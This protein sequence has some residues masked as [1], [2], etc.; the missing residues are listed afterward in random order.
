MSGTCAIS[1][2]SRRELS[3]SFF[4]PARQGKAPKEIW[5]ILTETL[6]CFLPGRAKDLS[7]PLYNLICQYYARVAH[8]SKIDCLEDKL[9]FFTRQE[10]SFWPR[11]LGKVGPGPTSLS[12]VSAQTNRMASTLI[13]YRQNGEDAS[14]RSVCEFI[15]ESDTKLPFK[16]F[17]ISPIYNGHT[18]CITEQ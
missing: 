17:W 10:K 9:K 3:S 12:I 13:C 7:A 18:R 8:C 11:R 14:S 4:F 16:K 5:A 6:A 1:T 15:R 2:T